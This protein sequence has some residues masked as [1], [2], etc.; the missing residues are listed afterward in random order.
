[1]WLLKEALK[2]LILGSLSLCYQ[3][4]SMVQPGAPKLLMS[5]MYLLC[6]FVCLSLL[7]NS[8]F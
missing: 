2:I 4:Q 7:L 5:L 6:S 3:Q 1:M 8:L